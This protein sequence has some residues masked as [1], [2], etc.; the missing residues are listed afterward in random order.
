MSEREKEVLKSILNN[1]K[2]IL[3]ILDRINK[4]QE[5]WVKEE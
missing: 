1:T 2:E 4:S 3:E 5:K